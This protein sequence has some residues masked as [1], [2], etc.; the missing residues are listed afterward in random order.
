LAQPIEPIFS[1]SES[2]NLLRTK[3]LHEYCGAFSCF[4]A[5]LSGKRP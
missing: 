5:A 2:L 4:F 3:R 1:L